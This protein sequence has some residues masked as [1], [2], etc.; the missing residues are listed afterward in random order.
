LNRPPTNGMPSAGRLTRSCA[1]LLLLCSSLLAQQSAEDPSGKKP[2]DEGFFVRKAIL[3]LSVDPTGHVVEVVLSRP[4]DSASCTDP[5]YYLAYGELRPR[6]VHVLENASHIFLVFPRPI[7]PGDCSLAVYGVKDATG[8][9][10]VPAPNV[11]VSPFDSI[12]PRVV[13]TKASAMAG[14]NADTVRVVFNERLVSSDAEDVANYELECPPGERIELEANSVAYDGCRTVTLHLRSPPGVLDKLTARAITRGSPEFAPKT[15]EL[16]RW[17][18]YRLHVSNVRD[19]S[20]NSIAPQTLRVGEVE[21]S[22]HG[23]CIVS[24]RLFRHSKRPGYDILVSL[25]R[26]LSPVCLRPENFVVSGGKIA[27]LRP[28]N[29]LCTVLITLDRTVKPPPPLWRRFIVSVLIVTA[30][31]LLY[32]LG[33]AEGEGSLRH[34]MRVVAI[35]AL[36]A[37]ALWTQF[38][39]GRGF[40]L[41]A[42]NLIDLAGNNTPR[43]E[44][45]PLEPPDTLYP[46]LLGTSFV[47]RTIKMRFSKRINP[48]DATD[49][50]HFKL[51]AGASLESRR[52]IILLKNARFSYDPVERSVTIDLPEEDPSSDAVQPG[53][54]YLLIVSGV[55]DMA[56]NTIRPDSRIDGVIESSPEAS[57]PDVASMSWER[58][59]PREKQRDFAEFK[60]AKTTPRPLQ[61]PVPSQRQ[62]S[63]DAEALRSAAAA[64]PR[65]NAARAATALCIQKSLALVVDDR[66]K[67][68]SPAA[69]HAQARQAAFWLKRASLWCKTGLSRAGRDFETFIILSTL[70]LTALGLWLGV[71][72]TPYFLPLLPGVGF[73]FALCIFRSG[74]HVRSKLLV[75]ALVACLASWALCWASWRILTR[76]RRAFAF[77]SLPAFLTV[78]AACAGLL[79]LPPITA[80]P[81]QCPTTRPVDAADDLLYEGIVARWQPSTEAN[82]LPTLFRAVLRQNAGAATAGAGFSRNRLDA[83]SAAGESRPQRIILKMESGGLIPVTRLV[84]V[85]ASEGASL[86]ADTLLAGK[87]SR[88]FLPEEANAIIVGARSIRALGKMPEEVVGK[89]CEVLGATVRIAGVF[90]EEAL[91]SFKDL[92]GSRYCEVPGKPLSRSSSIALAPAGFLEQWGAEP[93]VWVSAGT[94]D[95]DPPLGRMLAMLDAAGGALH[96]G[97]PEGVSSV[98]A[99]PVG[100]HVPKLHWLYALVFWIAVAAVS[101]HPAHRGTTA[102]SNG[103]ANPLRMLAGAGAAVLLAGLGVEVLHACG[104]DGP[105][106][107]GRTPAAFNLA[108]VACAVSAVAGVA[109]SVLFG[110]QERNSH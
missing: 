21:G 68:E 39:W 72:K 57:P 75:E 87:G 108:L 12:P 14:P 42:R 62:L 34:S 38:L 59:R 84:G 88:W 99:P 93:Y 104:R 103:F 43:C 29:D 110:R 20:G 106:I 17:E 80:N 109:S 22:P 64:L 4:A 3:S 47:D 82:C 69:L 50:Q 95:E 63:E 26:A 71:G 100:L 5:G 41:E 105:D 9:P 11:P 31:L 76:R 53:H 32:V 6:A 97:R 83:P 52:K 46:R 61:E 60:P 19:L 55:K 2:E 102:F 35:G 81:E 98:I 86:N 85:D 70:G 16:R 49:T 66:K 56:G 96:V 28:Y 36:L 73:F 33:P 90:S 92:D 65:G 101:L 74:I 91:R 40:R 44:S 51:E 1:A 94:V 13:S 8:K 67:S 30:A 27:R 79:L 10:L 78:T 23:P 54:K 25:D 45:P 7:V 107:L 37:A 89:K 58:F 24:T 18:Q 15:C 77:S 48:R